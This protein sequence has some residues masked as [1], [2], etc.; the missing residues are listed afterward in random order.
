MANEKTVINDLYNEIS[1]MFSKYKDKIATDCASRA[2]GQ[3]GKCKAMYRVTA[4]TKALPIVKNYASRC[5][6]VY[7]HNIEI[8]STNSWSFTQELFSEHNVERGIPSDP[9]HCELVLLAGGEPTGSRREAA[10]PEIL[11]P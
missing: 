8:M 11:D 6:V 10:R 1:K 7:P 3:K 5:I 2:F 4:Y 9:A